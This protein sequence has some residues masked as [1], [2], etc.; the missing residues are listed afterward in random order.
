MRWILLI[1]L[2]LVGCEEKSTCPDGGKVFGEAPPK[3]F[4]TTCKKQSATGAWAQHGPQIEWHMK[5]PKKME[6]TFVDG[7][8][9]GLRTEWDEA[10]KKIAEHTFA[11][12]ALHGTSTALRPDGSKVKETPYKEG[13]KEGVETTFH[14]NGK[15]KSEATFKRGV[16]VGEA[17]S[18]QEDG[19]L[20]ARIEWVEF[21]LSFYKMGVDVK[22]G[23][24]R[25]E[26]V[27]KPMKV[28]KT[29]V[30]VGQYQMC[31]AAGACTPPGSEAG[32]NFGVAGRSDHPVNCVDWKQARVFAKWAK[33]RLPTAAEWEF[34]AR[35]AGQERTYPWGSEPATCDYAA[36]KGCG[37]T[38]AKVCAKSKGKTSNGLCDLAGNVAEW[39][40]AGRGARREARGGGWQST[41]EEVAATAGEALDLNARA[42]TVG[43]RVARTVKR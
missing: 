4:Q 11:A 15:K 38:T 41:A 29:E 21:E 10:G 28:S 35:D 6:T 20:V 14:P 1:V 31:V 34:V 23:M 2:A 42:P 3:G 43:F 33:A 8:Q 24:A 39:V 16:R 19:T 26:E 40:Q 30:T 17:K 25:S 12:G 18:W 36:M 32:C 27:I 22:G 13:K 9:Q 37:P 7:K 5:G